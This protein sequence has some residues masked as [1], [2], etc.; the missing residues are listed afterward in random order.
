MAMLVT[1]ERAKS[2]EYVIHDADDAEITNKVEEAS[3]IVLDYVGDRENA[4]G[5]SAEDP[6]PADAIAVPGVISAAVLLVFGALWE[7]RDG[8]EDG[9]EP[10]SPAVKNLLRRYRDPVIA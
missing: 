2:Q 5:W 4:N 3:D 8:G 1:L 10:L 7:N 6:L 9:P